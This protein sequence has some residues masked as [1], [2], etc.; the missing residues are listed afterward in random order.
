MRGKGSLEAQVPGKGVAQVLD[1]STDLM[2]RSMRRHS[3][4]VCC[5]VLRVHGPEPSQTLDAD[6]CV[7]ALINHRRLPPC[8]LPQCCNC[9][10][11]PLS[12]ARVRQ[13]AP[14]ACSLAWSRVRS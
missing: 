3:V 14:L 12:R 9:V 8:R 6:D 13:H 4:P 1:I 5:A 10:S 11:D 2:L 7:I